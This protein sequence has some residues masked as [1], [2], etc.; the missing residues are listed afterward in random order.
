LDQLTDSAESFSVFISWAH[1]DYRSSFEEIDEEKEFVYSFVHFLARY[2]KIE[3]DI[4]HYT[5]EGMNWSLYGPRQ[6]EAASTVL[7]VGSKPFWERWRGDNKPDEG[8]GSVREIDALKG[9]FNRDQEQFQRK[10]VIALLP[11]ESHKDIP[12]ELHRVACFPVTSIDERGVEGLL[13]RLLKK[14]LHVPP[15]EKFVPNLPAYNPGFNALDHD[16]VSGS[17]A[18]ISSALLVRARARARQKPALVAVAVFVVLLLA[19]VLV[20]RPWSWTSDADFTLQV[21]PNRDLLVVTTRISLGGGSYITPLRPDEVG[22]PPLSLDSCAGRWSWAHDKRIRGVDAN[23]MMAR[24]DITAADKTLVVDGAGITTIGDVQVPLAGTRLGCGGQGGGEPPNL[25]V[26]DLEVNRVGFEPNADGMESVLNVEIP[27]RKTTSFYLRGVAVKY[28]KWCLELSINV[29][30]KDRRVTV[31]QSGA[32]IGSIE[33]HPELVPFQ[34]S[35]DENSTLYRF[36]DGEWR[37]ES[38]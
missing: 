25:L 29:D 27:P 35:G 28:H 6:V 16:G 12:D 15:A 18:T 21:E 9:L 17:T 31:S 34:I 5:D 22:P 13:R 14:P 33:S 38:R 3:A 2:M 19:A 11:G 7:I 4:F 26:A 36:Q 32:A 30:G 20:V 37:K 10:V 23:A 8:A 1:A 24:I